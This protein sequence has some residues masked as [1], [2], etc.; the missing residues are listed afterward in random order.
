MK[1]NKQSVATQKIVGMSL[2]NDRAHA[3]TVT[4]TAVKMKQVA[5]NIVLDFKNYSI[6]TEG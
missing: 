5:S 1:A 4:T 6:E 3:N 2:S